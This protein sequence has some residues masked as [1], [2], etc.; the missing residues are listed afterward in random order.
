MSALDIKAP[1]ELAAAHSVAWWTRCYALVGRAPGMGCALAWD[2]QDQSSFPLG[3]QCFGVFLFLGSWAHVSGAP[4]CLYHPRE[5]GQWIHQYS[6]P[7]LPHS[8]CPVYI[9]VRVL[10]SCFFKH[11]SPA[12]L[13]RHL[14]V[15][16]SLGN[17]YTELKPLSPYMFLM[18][19]CRKTAGHSFMQQACAQF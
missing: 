8:T 2:L 1:G 3:S 7:R 14:L 5:D 19:K 12:Y 18:K 11:T 16:K 15:L 17:V 4:E 9:E 13:H 6:N 10:P